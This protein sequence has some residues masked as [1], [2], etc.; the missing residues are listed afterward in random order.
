MAAIPQVIPIIKPQETLPVKKPIPQE[1]IAKA[2]KALPP[3]PVTIFNAL[4]RVF[5]KALSSAV[6][7]IDQVQP[8]IWLQI[9]AVLPSAAQ[10][11]GGCVL[12]PPHLPA[13]HVHGFWQAVTV[14]KV[15]HAGG[16]VVAPI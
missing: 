13:V 10:V 14:V 12:V 8:D 4:Q 5:V 15:V 1:M 11:F 7:L 16:V 2:A 6:A 9:A 3:V